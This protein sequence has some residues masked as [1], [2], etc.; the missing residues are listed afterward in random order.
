MLWNWWVVLLAVVVFV[1]IGA[2]IALL[3]TPTYT[4][5]ARLGVGRID[6]TSPGALSGYA[7]ATQA[8]A[9][10]YSR[11]VTAQ[12]VAR[13]VAAKTGLSIKD[14][15]DHVS[16]TPIAQSPVFRIEATSPNERQAVELANQSSRALIHYAAAL[17]RSNPDSGRL[18]RLYRAAI[19][20]RAQ[21]GRQL[22]TAEV[23][24]RARPLLSTEEEVAEASG[25]VQAA[26]LRVDALGKAYT[27]SLQSQVATQLVQVVS[28]A[29]EAKSDRRSTL[30]I[31]AFIG[32]IVGL[33]VG[34]GLAVMRES[35][36]R[37]GTAP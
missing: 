9:T 26:N 2:S 14:V 4:A 3:R 16:G 36:S 13:A 28:P 29:I 20:N 8:L 22:E 5:T 27:A 34:G 15:Q 10:G 21:T 25:A 30:L 1:A 31:L 33:L 24:A 35:E 6:I 11:T 32:L 12:P 7:V 23:D 17:N 37:L 19:V 18:Y